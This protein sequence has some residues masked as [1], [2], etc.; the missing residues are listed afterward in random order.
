MVGVAGDMERWLEFSPD[1]Y[2]CG[3]GEGGVE[4]PYL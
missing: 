3:K 1:Q 2:V 4:G